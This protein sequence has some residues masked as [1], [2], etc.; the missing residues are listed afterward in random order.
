MKKN[1]VAV[2]L[3]TLLFAGLSQPASAALH[4]NKQVGQIFQSAGD[5]CFYFQLVGV[6]QADPTVSTSPY[7][8]VY[9][10]DQAGKDML[11]TLLAAKASGATVT[12]DTQPGN[13][14]C[15]FA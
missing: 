15:G 7:F 9:R 5:P 12:I 13:T 1:R 2:L 14:W 6:T 10:A 4:S 8:A 11:A 3:M